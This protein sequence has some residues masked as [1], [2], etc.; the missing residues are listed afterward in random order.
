MTSPLI[1][2]Y[3]KMGH[4][5][6]ACFSGHAAE[7]AV[8]QR[9]ALLKVCHRTLVASEVQQADPYTPERQ[10]APLPALPRR[11]PEPLP[12]CPIVPSPGRGPNGRFL[13]PAA[14]AAL[15]A[16]EMEDPGRPPRRQ[17]A[18]VQQSLQTRH[19]LRTSSASC[20][21]HP[22]VVLEPQ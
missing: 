15:A 7:D 5:H 10:P 20:P 21:T 11:F 1:R 6:L 17:A 13:R 3:A 19:Q 2:Q 9:L 8:V 22:D 16:Q 14:A 18:R 4:P 12:P